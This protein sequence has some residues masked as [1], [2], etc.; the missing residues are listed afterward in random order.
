MKPLLLQHMYMTGCSIFSMVHNLR[1]YTFFLL[2]LCSLAILY[3]LGECRWAR[4]SCV[5][6]YCC[7]G[8]ISSVHIYTAAVYMCTMHNEEVYIT[9]CIGSSGIM[10][11]LIS[12]SL[13]IFPPGFVNLSSSAVFCCTLSPHLHR[14]L[15]VP[16]NGFGALLETFGI[17]MFT[18]SSETTRTWT[19]GLLQRCLGGHVLL[20]HTHIVCM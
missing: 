5:V 11:R 13:S 12:L 2:F 9:L 20:D 17:S 6:C 15:S 19:K 7:I 3:I 8:S 18:V 1:S 16:R 14:S 10:P 4:A